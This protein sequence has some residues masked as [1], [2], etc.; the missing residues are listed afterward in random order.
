MNYYIDIKV[1]ADPEFEA[2]TLLNALFAK[3]HRAL[4]SH[5]QGEIG[6]SF[7][8]ADKSL[9]EHIRLHGTQAALMRLE[10]AEWLKGLRDYTDVSPS[11][12]VPAVTQHRVIKR[13]QAKSNVERVIR[14]ALKRGL[15]SAEADV[16]R[17][18]MK[19]RT[20]AN[21]YLQ[22]KSLSTGQE[23]RLFID[24]GQLVTEPVAGA[25]SAYGL[26]DKATV[27]WF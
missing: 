9:G 8:M 22:I 13:V 3:L 26:S 15:S 18:N 11:L 2:T 17:E 14:R 25:F 27:P 12:A 10:Q 21:P 24:Q 7:P 6:I 23:F 20:L 5:G 16:R 19:R 4:A 1:L